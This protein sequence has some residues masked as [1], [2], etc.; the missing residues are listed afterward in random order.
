MRQMMSQA[1]SPSI[2]ALLDAR[3]A[4]HSLPQGLYTRPDVFEADLDVLFRKHWIYVGL[5][6]DVPEPGDAS[7]VEAGTSSIIL[8]RDDDGRIQVLHNVCRHR[9][10]RLLPPGPSV[11]SKAR[12]AATGIPDVGRR[13]AE[14]VSARRR[15]A[16]GLCWTCRPR[17]RSHRPARAHRTPGR[18]RSSACETARRDRPRTRPG[19][20]RG[21]AA[22]NGR[23]SGHRAGR[24]WRVKRPGT[25]FAS[26]II[27]R[28][29]SPRR[30][31]L[32]ATN[33]P[34]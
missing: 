6:C 5:E 30:T 7:V 2:S 25:S 21:L 32:N 15:R 14:P 10:S 13:Y 12:E 34:P 16:A 27:K 11:V 8:L 1:A 20:Y 4:G 9:G 31:L 17:P 23:P 28:S 29:L 26:L 19:A 24:K 22:A 3:L 33:G 18:H